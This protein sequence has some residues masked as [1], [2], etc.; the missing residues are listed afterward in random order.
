M[1]DSYNRAKPVYLPD[2]DPHI[3]AGLFKLF[4]RELPEPVLTPRLNSLF[5]EACG[6]PDEKSRI[7]RFVDLV[8]QL[9]S[10]NK[11]VL[12]WTIVHM[13]HVIEQ[14]KVNK[15]SLENVSIVLSPTMKISHRVLNVFFSHSRVF[16]EEDT[17]RKFVPTIKQDASRM[18]LDIPG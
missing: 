9:P 8:A 13:V 7:E 14:E 1:K 18:S 12:A 2:Y 16:F 17:L 15:M 11:L 6:L 10:L 3:V 5:D 4:L